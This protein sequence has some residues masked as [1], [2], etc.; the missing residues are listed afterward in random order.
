MHPNLL[1]YT[2][3]EDG[4]P[5]TSEQKQQAKVPFRRAI[6]KWYLEGPQTT[7]PE[8]QKCPPNLNLK[9]NLKN[10]TKCCV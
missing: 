6:K 9:L 10:Q 2:Q 3:N 8:K 4:T 5:K 7:N 1:I